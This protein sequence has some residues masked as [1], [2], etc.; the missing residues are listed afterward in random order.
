MEKLIISLPVSV[1]DKLYSIEN[2]Q[3]ETYIVDNIELNTSVKEIKAR[4]LDIKLKLLH[5]NGCS[6]SGLV[7][8]KKYL[9][10]RYFVSKKE[11]LKH[12][13]DQI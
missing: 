4:E 3:L 11:L 9:N 8:V 5:S 12:I 10:K 13:M 6:V 7:P 2:G 1:G